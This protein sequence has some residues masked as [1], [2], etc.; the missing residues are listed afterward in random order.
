LGLAFSNLI[1][2]LDPDVIVI[3]GSVSGARDLF[4]DAMYQTMRARAM[5]PYAPEQTVVFSEMPDR[6]ALCGA[7]LFIRQAVCPPEGPR[8]TD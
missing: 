6:A 3:G 2:L 8:L 5:L 1:N 7:H 4:A